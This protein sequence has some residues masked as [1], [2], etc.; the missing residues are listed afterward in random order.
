MYIHFVLR[1]LI[2]RKVRHASLTTLGVKNTTIAAI[3]STCIVWEMNGVIIGDMFTA[4]ADYE[5]TSSI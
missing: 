4:C 2:C 3:A 5:S 1:A